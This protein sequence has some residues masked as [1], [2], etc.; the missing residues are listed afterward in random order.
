MKRMKEQKRYQHELTKRFFGEDAE[1]N[2][3]KA[4]VGW[5]ESSGGRILR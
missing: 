1:K 5:G 4:A 2:Q 3:G